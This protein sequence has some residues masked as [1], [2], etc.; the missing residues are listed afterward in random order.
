MLGSDF[1]IGRT[2]YLLSSLP[3]KSKLAVNIKIVSALVVVDVIAKAIFSIIS[4]IFFSLSRFF[5]I[6]INK[7]LF[8][9][10]I[11][12]IVG[13]IIFLAF[14]GNPKSAKLVSKEP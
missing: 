7:F 10:A 3:F 1:S 4:T 12:I 2:G 6:E 9:F 5:S 11:I 8:L 13:G 14:I